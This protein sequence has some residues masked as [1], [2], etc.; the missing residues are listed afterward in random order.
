MYDKVA[1]LDNPY[2][3]EFTEFI[4]EQVRVQQ[5]MDAREPWPWT[6]SEDMPC[7][8][9]R[10]VPWVCNGTKEATFRGRESSD[11]HYL[12]NLWLHVL[13][14]DKASDVM[15]YVDELE[16]CLNQF[17]K[18]SE[19]RY[20]WRRLNAAT[21]AIKDHVMPELLEFNFGVSEET[22][23]D[24]FKDFPGQRKVFDAMK[25]FKQCGDYFAFYGSCD[26][27]KLSVSKYDK[28][29]CPPGKSA[30]LLLGMFGLPKNANGMSFCLRIVGDQIAN[31]LNNGFPGKRLWQEEGV[32]REIKTE[33]KLEPNLAEEHEGDASQAPTLEESDELL[34]DESDEMVDDSEDRV[35]LEEDLHVELNRE[36][37]A[38]CVEEDMP[39]IKLESTEQ[40]S[41]VKKENVKYSY[42]LPLWPVEIDDLSY[43]FH[44]EILKP[45]WKLQEAERDVK[46]EHVKKEPKVKM[47]E[48][49]ES[50]SELSEME[51]VE[52]DDNSDSNSDDDDDES[53]SSDESDFYILIED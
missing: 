30:K 52:A 27:A 32:E 10:Y 39:I 51:E 8:G 36:S 47:T 37:S 40:N 5:K 38:E 14:N 12:F 23:S 29:L 6:E 17:E 46:K 24:L 9:V 48:D 42:L 31:T 1:L 44:H 53:S 25:K 7:L 34:A 13:L 4:T 49:S 50:D 41:E 3:Q 16:P 18:W 35:V 33:V 28:T 15:G 43:W 11:P 22:S 21:I 2:F 45:R 20:Q 26:T 19:K